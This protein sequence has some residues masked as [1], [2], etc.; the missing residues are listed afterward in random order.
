MSHCKDD[1][2]VRHNCGVNNK[3]LGYDEAKMMVD[4]RFKENGEVKSH[5]CVVTIEINRKQRNNGGL[6][7]SFAAISPNTPNSSDLQSQ[8]TQ[9]CMKSAVSIERAGYRG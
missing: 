2:V 9:L 3:F 8:G 6:P 4:Y 7:N 5:T 1:S